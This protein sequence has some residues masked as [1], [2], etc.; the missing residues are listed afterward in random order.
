MIK[1]N[2]DEIEQLRRAFEKLP[3]EI[4]T[5]VMASAM[6]KLRNT[7]RTRVV[8]E[9]S[10]HVRLPPGR[11]RDM[12]RA[13]FNAGGNTQKMIVESGWVHLY[14]LGAV[15]D[16]LGVQVAG[17][18]R[19]DHA[20]I[21]GFKSGHAGVMLRVPGTQMPSASENKRKP[22]KLVKREKIRELFGPNPA[23][24]ITNNPE[25]YIEV[26]AEIV[27]DELYPSYEKALGMHLRYLR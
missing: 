2:A 13:A 9:A 20:F 23:H 7:A 27:R 21:T 16:H 14:G 4:K 3:G 19:I 10:K 1:L 15:Q 11:I 17:R 8:A 25:R 12:T 22:G 18:G 24:A 5:K 6:I 26:L